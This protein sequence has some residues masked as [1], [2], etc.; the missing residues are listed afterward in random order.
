MFI[1][2]V[3]WGENKN[4]RI[5]SLSQ[6]ILPS[7]SNEKR[8]IQE[9]T[10]KLQV[11][12]YKHQ[13]YIAAFQ[14]KFTNKGQKGIAFST[15]F[16]KEMIVLFMISRNSWFPGQILTSWNSAFFYYILPT[17][18]Q[19]RNFSLLSDHPT[20]HQQQVYAKSPSASMSVASWAK[21]PPSS[22]PQDR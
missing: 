15:V 16:M 18:N 11:I 20:H 14:R 6:T 8:N 4:C 2:Y 1:S 22:E 19:F 10:P 13:Y 12:L 5:R 17:Q 9:E 7:R 3:F 21:W